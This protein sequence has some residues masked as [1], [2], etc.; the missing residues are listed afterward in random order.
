MI[1]ILLFAF[2]AVF[3]WAAMRESR[4][5]RERIRRSFEAI[6][7]QTPEG[8]VGGGELQV[9]REVVDT[10]GAS[11]GG[12]GLQGAFRYCI[13][14]GPSYFVVIG[15]MVGEGWLRRRL[16]WVVRPLSEERM[17]AAL[18][19]DRKALAAAFGEVE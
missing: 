12:D 3:I 13:G 17:R 18:H 9:V 11:E 7:V 6:V 14:P 16:Q 8:P 19:G 15:Q 2:V 1:E 10:A 4:L 5:R